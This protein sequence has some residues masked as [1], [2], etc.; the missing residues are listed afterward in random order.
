MRL[1]CLD[2]RLDDRG[3]G[4][5]LAD[6]DE[7]VVGR[8]A[9]AEGVLRAIGEVASRLVA[10]ED[11][12]LDVS[13]PHPPVFLFAPSC[14]VW[15]KSPCGANAATLACAPDRVKRTTATVSA[16]AGSTGWRRRPGAA[17]RGPATAGRGYDDLSG[18]SMIS[19]GEAPRSWHQS[20]HLE[21]N[22][23]AAHYGPSPLAACPGEPLPP[24]TG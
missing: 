23:M 1:G 12:R 18:H 16:C 19:S 15:R 14:A 2:R 24:P 13:D 22:G 21:R 7:A 17:D 20:Q 3:R 8:D 4:V 9:D 6:P 5:H 10:A 11:D